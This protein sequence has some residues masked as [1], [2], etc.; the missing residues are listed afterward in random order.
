MIYIVSNIESLIDTWIQI[1][2]RTRP[3]FTKKINNISKEDFKTE[4]CNSNKKYKLFYNQK[5]NKKLNKNSNIKKE[6]VFGTLGK[7]IQIIKFI[8]HEILKNIFTNKKGK[9]SNF[10]KEEFLNF[11]K[12]S[13]E[14]R[15]KITH[16]TFV[17][18]HKI[19][20]S[21]FNNSINKRLNIKKGL[22]LK[23][24]TKLIFDELDN[25]LKIAG[26]NNIRERLINHINLKMK[27]TNQDSKVLNEN[28]NLEFILKK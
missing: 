21:I 23:E 27:E 7:K 22:D 24:K 12:T 9:T 19:W 20:E 14:I 15:N 10:T 13:K 28:L 4:I 6:I 25:V 1:E 18:S 16:N 5:L 11:L 3:I 8:D 26:Y 17:L 2:S